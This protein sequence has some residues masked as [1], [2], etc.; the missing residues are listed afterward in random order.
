MA[1]RAYI[2]LLLFLGWTLPLIPLQ[3]LLQRLGHPFQKKLPLL[4]HRVLAWL[5]RIQIRIEGRPEANGPVLFIANHISWIDIVVLSTV[6]P[7][8]FVA[9]K[10][11]NTWPFFGL[12]A[13]LHPLLSDDDPVVAE[14]AAWA[15]ERL[16]A[17]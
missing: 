9:K 6:V 2:I 7:V 15:V 4:Y 3:Y 12:L 14:A 16:S 10:E 11:V 17:S 1:L 5:L 13:R 8:S